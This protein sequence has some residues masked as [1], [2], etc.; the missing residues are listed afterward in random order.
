MD[1]NALYTK[2]F[3]LADNLIT[4]YMAISCSIIWKFGNSAPNKISYYFDQGFKQLHTRLLIYNDNNQSEQYSLL[5]TER[6][7]MLTVQRIFKYFEP[8]LVCLNF[9]LILIPL[10]I[11]FSLEYLDIMVPI[12]K[13]Q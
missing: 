1:V 13:F 5:T 8:V 10:F 4:D 3:I 11:Y 6:G 9:L 2:H 7:P 12:F